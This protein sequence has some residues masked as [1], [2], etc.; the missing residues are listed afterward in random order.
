MKVLI[1]EDETA[2]AENLEYL[3]RKADPGIEIAANT[4]SVEQTL[5]WLLQNTADLIFMDIHLSDGSAFSLFDSMDVKTPIIFTTA[6]DQYALDAFKVNSI[7]YL[8]KPI[9]PSE[10][11]RA[12][13][14]FH[15]LSQPDINQYVARLNSIVAHPKYVSRLLISEKDKIIPLPVDNIACI[16][17][18]ERKT[19]IITKDSKSL[20]YNRPLDAIMAELD[21]AK[22]IR[23]NKQF[24]IS[25]DA[26]AD[27]TVWFDNRLRV[28]LSVSTPEEIYIAKNRVSEFKSW[29]TE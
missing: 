15:R 13:D 27:I 3:L 9:K 5:D 2:A 4:E 1:V 26:V 24:I 18:T 14:K 25:R 10:L 29:L 16:Y 7:D 28:R 22:F 17:C 11:Q 19:D 20:R 8:L 21:P 6:Y 23:A 12:L